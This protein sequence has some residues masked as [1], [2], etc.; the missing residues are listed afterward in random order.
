MKCFR[1]QGIKFPR[2][3]NGGPRPGQLI[4]GQLT[5]SLALQ[6]LH[7]PRYAGAFCFGRTRY[8]IGSDGQKT[9]MALPQDQWQVL[10]KDKHQGYISWEQ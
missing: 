4:W 6:V 8:R 10:I 5:Q 7:N 9:S 3:S 2:R 1:R